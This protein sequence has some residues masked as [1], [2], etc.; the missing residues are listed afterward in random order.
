MVKTFLSLLRI[1]SLPAIFSLFQKTNFPVKF[2]FVAK[3]IKQILNV[4]A[5]L[6]AIFNDFPCLFPCWQ[7]NFAGAESFQYLA[8]RHF[9]YFFWINAMITPGWSIYRDRLDSLGPSSSFRAF[10]LVTYYKFYCLK[11]KLNQIA[12]NGGLEPKMTAVAKR[13]NVWNTPYVICRSTDSF[14]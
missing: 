2:S 1:L 4:E 7:G 6:L 14:Q 5:K 8:Q 11:R 10:N 12:A 9:P 13:M 3:F